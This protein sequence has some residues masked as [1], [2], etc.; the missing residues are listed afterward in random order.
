MTSRLFLAALALLVLSSHDMFLKLDDYHLP[1]D[2]E[3]TIQLFNGTFER[4]DNTIDRN[5]MIDVSLVAGG[6]RTRLDSSQWTERDSTTYLHFRTGAPGTYAVGLSTRSRD[7]TMEAEAFNNYLE[8]DG[9]LDMLELRRENGTLNDEAR[10]RYSKHVK[11]IFQVGETL[12]D[13][14]KTVLGY[15]IEFVPLENP[16]AAHAGHAVKFRL[17]RGGEPL[18]DQLVYAAAAGDGHVH[19]H[20][21]EDEPHDHTTGTTQLRTDADGI[22]S[23]DLTSDGVWYLRT[24]HLVESDEPGLTHESNWSTLTFQVGVGDHEHGAMAGGHAHDHG[25]GHS[26]SHAHKQAGPPAYVWWG[27]SLLLIGGLFFWFN[28][29]S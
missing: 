27:G 18:A 29:R 24:I 17:L 23:V 21:G 15:P 12:T 7:F 20:D 8:H 14:W 2:R 9:V 22:I 3:A 11:T 5:R 10:E 4:S 19:T 16:Y 1:P 6:Q 13:D 25:E 26:H 28:R